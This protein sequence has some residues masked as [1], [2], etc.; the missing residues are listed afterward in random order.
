MLGLYSITLWPL[1]CTC[2]ITCTMDRQL[3]SSYLLTNHPPL[4]LGIKA[5]VVCVNCN[6]SLAINTNIHPPCRTYTL[7][8]EHTPSLSTSTFGFGMLY[9]LNF[10]CLSTHFNSQLSQ[11][12]FPTPLIVNKARLVAVLVSKAPTVE[13]CLNSYF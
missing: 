1:A 2:T 13:L 12:N 7:P 3:T 5:F 9:M 11:Y 10:R 4:P 8:V 6:A